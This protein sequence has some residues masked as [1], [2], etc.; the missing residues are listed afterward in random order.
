MVFTRAM[1]RLTTP[2]KLPDGRD[3]SHFFLHKFFE[4][5]LFNAGIFVLLP[6]AEKGHQ[7][8]QNDTLVINFRSFLISHFFLSTF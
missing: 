4:Q 3:F 1:L 7:F 5:P 2:G 6:L 8:V